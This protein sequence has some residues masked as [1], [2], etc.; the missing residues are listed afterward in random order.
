MQQLS[1][2]DA[3]ESLSFPEDLLEYF[4]GFLAPQQGISLMHQLIKE[5]PW[6]QQIIQMFGKEVI[7][8]RLTAWFGD[9]N[10]SYQFSGTRFDPV[11]WTLAL[12]NLK[13]KIQK[14]T[15]LPFN[16][17]LLN[18]YRDGNDSVAWHS[19]NEK[20][21]GINPHIASVSIGQARQFEF[22]HKT[23]HSRKYGLSLE[24][25]SLLIMKGD[26][27]HNWEHR[28]PK[29]KKLNNERINLTFRS[30]I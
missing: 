6:R 17:V 16:S 9:S 23:D 21:L 3:N 19:D 29:S 10:K 28:I 8:P 27:Q 20:E 5:V 1:L 26:L 4:P 11:P 22:R 14:V 30:I 7:T 2:F 12:Y 18:F 13:E 25:G 24:N 15:G